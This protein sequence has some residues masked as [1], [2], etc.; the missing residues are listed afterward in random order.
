MFIDVK[1]SK[2]NQDQS[3]NVDITGELDVST[4]DKLKKELNQML[5]K[6]ILSINLNMEKLEYIDSTGLGV[7]IGILKRIKVE[8][9]EITIQN[10]K[11][12]IKK[13]FSITGLDKIF[14][15]EG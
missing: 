5:D 2:N 9:K 13:I 6:S 10:P 3:W 8:E 15:M 7:L 4:A 14:I 1:Y 12:N 11:N